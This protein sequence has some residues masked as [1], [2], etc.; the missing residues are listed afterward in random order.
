M[1]YNNVSKIIADREIYSVTTESK[2]F[3]FLM[4]LL[5]VWFVVLGVIFPE[6]P[7]NL[8]ERTLLRLL[9]FALAFVT[10]IFVPRYKISFRE[11]AVV[12]SV[13]YYPFVKVRLDRNKITHV[14]LIEWIPMKH[15][16][17]AGIKTGYG[18]FKNYWCFN[19]LGG[20]G[21]EIKT[22][23]KNYVIEVGEIER[24]RLLSMIGEYARRK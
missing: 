24:H 12:I 17:G 18:K 21:I 5:V 23:E 13:G 3:S 2:W 6:P 9:I 15:F 1:M 4:L 14:G 8:M 22:T 16:G 20:K 11:S 10:F 19:V 7:E